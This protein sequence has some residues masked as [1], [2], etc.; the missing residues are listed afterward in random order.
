LVLFFDPENK[1]L[2]DVGSVTKTDNA[3]K[4]FRKRWAAKQGKTEIEVECGVAQPEMADLTKAMNAVFL[5]PGEALAGVV[6]Y[7]WKRYLEPKASGSPP[8]LPEGAAMV[9]RVGGTV[10]AP[11]ETYAPNPSYTELARQA[12]YQAGALLWL[13][14]D[15]DGSTRSIMIVRPAG[16]GLDES[17]VDAVRTWRFD[18]AKRD[19]KEV[20]VQVNIEVNFHLY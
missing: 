5:A 19:G 13:I 14:V 20:S 16:M 11:R 1:Q 4:L 8:P 12:G 6:P 9:H 15:R 10:S 18:P 2:R 17:A 3:R 7:F